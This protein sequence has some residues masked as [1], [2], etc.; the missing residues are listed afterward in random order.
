LL[1]LFIYSKTRIEQCSLE[2]LC[3][4]VIACTHRGAG[5]YGQE[6]G[7][8]RGNLK[9]KGEIASFPPASLFALGWRA[10]HSQWQ[11]LN[12]MCFAAYTIVEDATSKG[13][14][15]IG[16]QREMGFSVRRDAG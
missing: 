2:V 5:P 1:A 16:V 15:L 9:E 3:R 14:A 10:G 7:R 12:L 11:E 6:A 8:V 13:S 4:C